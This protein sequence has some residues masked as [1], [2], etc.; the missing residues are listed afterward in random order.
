MALSAD[1]NY[2][3]I[4][5]YANRYVYVYN[6]ANYQMVKQ[7]YLNSQ[8]TFMDTSPNNEYLAVYESDFYKVAIINIPGFTIQSY[9]TPSYSP[10]SFKFDYNNNLLIDLANSYYY[11]TLTRYNIAGAPV[12]VN[13]I[14]TN[15]FDNYPIS[16]LSQD[17]K[18]LYQIQSTLYKWDLT[19]TNSSTNL[20]IPIN[21]N[22]PVS[23]IPSPDEQL[24]YILYNW[25][26]VQNVPVYNLN[27][28]SLVQY[29][30]CSVARRL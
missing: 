22:L 3:F 11:T 30:Y 6:T 15:F 2:L 5:D 21:N 17:R 1:G 7:I 16:C 23:L 27:T 14:F 19:K 28:S 12:I 18:F 24:I 20:N 8:P 25:Y 29:L 13:N 4:S 10:N 26:S 9:I